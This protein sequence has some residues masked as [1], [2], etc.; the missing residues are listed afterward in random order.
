M[1]DEFKD[2]HIEFKESR[3]YMDRP[4]Y[5]LAFEYADLKLSREIKVKKIDDGSSEVMGG[6]IC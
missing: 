6:K 3:G 2:V 5:F 1:E 4:I